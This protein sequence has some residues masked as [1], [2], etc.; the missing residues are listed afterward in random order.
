LRACVRNW[1]SMKSWKPGSTSA[2]FLDQ[3]LWFCRSSHSR[4]RCTGPQT[5]LGS[6][7]GLP[8]SGNGSKC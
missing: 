7:P 4:A 6:F 3:C 5:D 1:I 2:H 8:I